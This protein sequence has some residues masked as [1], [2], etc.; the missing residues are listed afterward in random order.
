MA[1]FRGFQP[2]K[3]RQKPSKT[4]VMTMPP[5]A[6]TA[7]PAGD[8]GFVCHDLRDHQAREP[9]P[10]FSSYLGALGA[11]AVAFGN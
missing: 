8:F 4:Q 7:T 10:F 1:V 5:W 6:N 11:L 2:I 3:D 9:F